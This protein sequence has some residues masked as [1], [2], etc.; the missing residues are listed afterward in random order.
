MSDDIYEVDRIIGRRTCI[1]RRTEYMIY[2]KGYDRNECSWVSSAD[3]DCELEVDKFETRC[4][5]L[6]KARRNNAAVPAIDRYEAEGIATLIDVA[7]EIFADTSPFRDEMDDFAFGSTAP[8]TGTPV[9]DSSSPGSGRS[10]IA[11]HGWN[12]AV[13]NWQTQRIRGTISTT[14]GK[15]FYLTE[16]TDGALTWEQ[17]DMFNGSTGIVAEFENAKFYRERRGLVR[18]FQQSK[19]MADLSIVS[20]R[21][22]KFMMEKVVSREATQATGGSISPGAMASPTTALAG[23]EAWFDLG[24]SKLHTTAGSLQHGRAVKATRSSR[25]NVEES[26][27]ES[28]DS[29]QPLNQ[30]SGKTQYE[31]A[32]DS[33]EPLYL[34]GQKLVATPRA[35]SEP[36]E[37]Q[38]PQQQLPPQ[39]LSARVR[40]RKAVYVYIDHEE[41]SF[42][43]T[44]SGF[45]S[46]EEEEE[47]LES[48][49]AH[50]AMPR[51]ATAASTPM[52]AAMECGFCNKTVD[53]AGK[54]WTCESCGLRCHDK[55]YRQL[56]K[57]LGAGAAYGRTLDET[58]PAKFTCRFCREYA[59]RAAEKV[60]TW[61]LDSAASGSGPQ[62]RV[63]VAVKW[64]ERSYRHLDWVP[65]AWL[66]RISRLTQLRTVRQQAEQGESGPSLAEAVDPDF[67]KP[68]EIIGVQPAAAVAAQRRRVQLAVR[69]VSAEA[70]ELY[71]AYA[72]VRVVWRGLDISEATWEA[73]PSPADG[74]SEY[75]PWHAAFVA[76]R[77]AESVSAAKQQRLAAPPREGAREHTQQPDYVA[78]GQ[79]KDYQLVGAQWL[80]QRWQAGSGAVLAD[81]MGM[82]KTIQTIAFL[83]MAYHSTLDAACDADADAAAASN[84]GVFP[85]L[86][87]AP[88]TLVGN[89]AREFATWA[90][91][92]VVAQLSGRAA[93]RTE[94][95]AHTVF[96]REPG[97]R[98]DLKCHVVLTSYEAACNAEAAAA[99][100]GV[101]WQALVV[102]EGHRLK[103]DAARTFQSLRRFGAR[104]RVVLTGTPVQNCLREL[105]SVLAFIEPKKFNAAAL[106]EKYGAA[107]AAD[108]AAV[109]ALVRPL[110]LRR[111]KR[112]Q[113]LLV[114]PKCEAI[115]PV[116][117]TRL[118][119]ELY[120]ATLTRNAQLLRGIAAAMQA[121]AEEPRAVRAAPL[122]NVLMEV[123]RILSHP[124]LLRNVEPA[125]LAPREQHLRLIDA[126]AKLQL[127]HVLLPE[128][129]ARGHRLLLFAQFKD[130]LDILE[131]YLD[132]EDISYERIDGD[133]SAADRQTAVAAFSRTDG[134]PVFLATTRTGGVGLNL[135]AADTVII[136][137]CDFNP[138]ADL[139][140]MA[141]AHR[142]GQKRPVRVFK[143]VTRDSAEERILRKA[144]RK[145][146]L[147]HQIIQRIDEPVLPGEEDDSGAPGDVERALRHGADLLFGDRAEERAEE[148]AIRYD[149]QRVVELL[150][151]CAGELEEKAQ[152]LRREAAAAAEDML[153]PNSSRLEDAAPLEAA[154]TPS[155]A[156]DFARVWAPTGEGAL[157]DDSDDADVWA[158]LLQNAAADAA[159]TAGSEAGGR[160][161]RTRKRN[162]NYG[163]GRFTEASS[164]ADYDA[165]H[166]SEDDAEEDALDDAE[167]HDAAAP[168]RTTGPVVVFQSDILSIVQIHCQRLIDRYVQADAALGTPIPEDH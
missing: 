42:N 12:R 153:Q 10:L 119:R 69:G 77:R 124:Y 130:T 49:V 168:V 48:G 65:L 3:L 32:D 28:S 16:W 142:I 15:V 61:R 94:Q 146:E 26:G 118:Q 46:D 117:M 167:G 30:L 148:R 160:K 36:F 83:Q 54:Q 80:W 104:Q 74:P 85:F 155:A 19:R 132:G 97:G 141:R 143:L 67:L 103:N 60:V 39:P 47:M 89:W 35:A 84:R 86:V 79:L 144:T 157:S 154:G 75:A 149:R 64:R 123:R 11:T 2:W 151:E 41:G 116:T 165:F 53:G 13:G 159:P 158:R 68:A 105:F 128:L 20:P 63:D 91:E 138:Q 62:G 43:G 72:Q 163:E 92:L 81:E 90:P 55:C 87:V 18:L 76:W 44:T 8:L 33:D 110:L 23:R 1:Q 131:D 99:L 101:R 40:P 122:R 147:D 98:R 4:F 21:Q 135:T 22:P 109:R 166:D 102:D 120:R 24:T 156:A 14:A 107:Q 88:T 114:P 121:G 71:C 31:S 38:E 73:P 112:D 37:S 59:G 29:D 136:Y 126:S 78:G 27:E 7:Q 129:F 134:A 45:E 58:N 106:E 150:D 162:V 56:V 140:A 50:R 145:L 95:L 115:L 164:D 70:G 6:R 52:S 34:Q 96:R 137:D 25:M 125:G 82:G 127:L 133:T 152:R 111:T 139:Q 51:T 93:C 108:V 161:L 9:S 17:A 66:A 57:R 100:A 113:P 5:E